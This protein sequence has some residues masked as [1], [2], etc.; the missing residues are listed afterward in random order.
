MNLKDILQKIAKG[1]KEPFERKG[2]K[3][4]RLEKERLEKERLE[5]ER[6]K[7]ERLE[8][9]RLKK[10]RLE[11]ERLEQERLEKERLEKERLEKQRLERE[12]LKKERLE[13]K[14]KESLEKAQKK[15]QLEQEQQKAAEIFADEIK[16]AYKQVFVKVDINGIDCFEK[17]LKKI[18]SKYKKQVGEERLHKLLHDATKDWYFEGN[19]IVC[20]VLIG[21][22]HLY[23]HKNMTVP[24]GDFNEI[25]ACY[26]MA[27][28]QA[29]AIA[30]RALHFE[31][32]G[33]K[34]SGYKSIAEDICRE[35]LSNVK[36]VSTDFASKIKRYDL[37]KSNVDIAKIKEKYRGA[38]NKPVWLKDLYEPWYLPSIRSESY[39]ADSLCN[40]YWKTI[41]E[42]REKE[43]SID[44]NNIFSVIYAEIM[45]TEE[46]CRAIEKAIEKKEMEARI[47][48]MKFA[49][50]L[51]AEMQK[52]E[53][54][55]KIK[56][57]CYSCEHWMHCGQF[58]ERANCSAYTPK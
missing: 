36:F 26:T 40:L 2:L 17:E 54:E 6:L 41:V 27:K 7:K 47:K 46:E 45:P 31:K 55:A 14:E 29:S 34:Q 1:I 3:Q 15:E 32:N 57:Q 50:A 28:I 19:T 44:P 8:Q 22:M 53:T 24:N 51:E 38:V 5:Q 16:E 56:A 35:Y 4:E 9:E 10:E 43:A 11:K 48:E 21:Q 13:K 18:D 33:Q 49:L 25:E 20:Q 23:L 39:Y 58:G 12:R 30:L 37:F 42:A 52:N